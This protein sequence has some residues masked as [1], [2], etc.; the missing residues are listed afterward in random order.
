MFD[1]GAAKYVEITTAPSQE[2]LISA[3]L[4]ERFAG[5]GQRAHAVTGYPSKATLLEIDRATNS[6]QPLAE[7]GGHGRFEQLAMAG[8]RL[9]IVDE[10]VSSG[11]YLQQFDPQSRAVQ[12]LTKASTVLRIVALGEDFMVFRG[13][14]QPVQR[15][16][17][18]GSVADVGDVEP[19][20]GSPKTRD[21]KSVGQAGGHVLVTAPLGEEARFVASDGGTLFA[22]DASGVPALREV[23]P[24]VQQ[25]GRLFFGAETAADE[26]GIF[27]SYDPQTRALSRPTDLGF[28]GDP[29]Y[30]ATSGAVVFVGTPAGSEASL[31]RLDDQGE[32]PVGLVDCA[33]DYEKVRFLQGI[34]D[35]VYFDGVSTDSLPHLLVYDA[36]ADKVSLT[37]YFGTESATRPTALAAL[38][39]QLFCTAIAEGERRAVRL[40]R[41]AC[42]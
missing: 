11:G 29:R 21:L 10:G 18:E 17:L 3:F 40:C 19:I 24:G 14:A 1:P 12:E 26:A 30:A 7:V 32:R 33:T 2:K 6:A 37:T 9:L 8:P 35:R 42:Q 15:V 16:S 41:S 25:G 38:G 31:Y 22:V 23:Y 5:A 28:S 20:W 4:L 36:V 39:Q 13:S 34:G 27:L